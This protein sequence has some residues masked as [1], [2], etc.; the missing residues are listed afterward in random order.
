MSNIPF[1][2]SRESSE[3]EF[4]SGNKD[5]V[6]GSKISSNV[7]PAAVEKVDSVVEDE[8]LFGWV[9]GTGGILSKVAEKTV[10]NLITTLD[11]QMKDYIHS[12]GKIRVIVASDEAEVIS[13]VKDA[14]HS[15][16]GL[17]TIYGLPSQPKNVAAQPVGFAAG[18]QGA[19]ERLQLIRETHVEA[20]EEDTILVSCE[21][22]LL[23]VGDEEWIEQCIFILDNKST[24]ICQYTQPTC[25]PYHVIQ[26]LQEA[27]S[28]EYPL[29]W[30]GF[31]VAFRPVISE[32]LNVATSKWHEAL[33]GLPR[34]VLLANAAKSLVYAYKLSQPQ[35]KVDQI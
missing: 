5:E 10:S 27:T 34:K 8:G 3:F 19:I 33:S 32:Y 21:S 25:V 22:F 7:K 13:A 23:E 12:G 30:S 2:A 18:K 1:T 17:A 9:K 31:S 16:F 6:T 35:A 29:S 11:P 26:K 4:V 14:F 24:R 15:I 28:A 20:K